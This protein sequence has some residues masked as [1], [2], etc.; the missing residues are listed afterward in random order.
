VSAVRMLAEVRED[1]ERIG[2]R[3]VLARDIGGI[4]DIMRRELGPHALRDVYPTVRAALDALQAAQN[5]TG[6][7]AAP[8]G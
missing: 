1:L 6:A 4:R 5:E 7:S 2:V 3:L 8:N